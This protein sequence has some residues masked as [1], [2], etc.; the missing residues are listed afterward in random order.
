MRRFRMIYLAVVLL[1]LMV[2]SSCGS[3]TPSDRE[4][5]DFN[6]D[7]FEDSTNITNPWFPLR[8]GTQFVFEGETIENG[9]KVPHRVM[10]TV[11][12]LR[13]RVDHKCPPASA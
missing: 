2:V 4:F 10:I 1:L 13:R 11:T 3:K 5:Q 12:D 6:V 9:G 8:P 7:N